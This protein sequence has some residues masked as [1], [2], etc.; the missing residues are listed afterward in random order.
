M[1][2]I[3]FTAFR[4]QTMNKSTA[5]GNNKNVVLD[6]NRSVR[7][8]HC[9][10]ECELAIGVG[11][12]CII[13]PNDTR[14]RIRTDEITL[15]RIT[16]LQVFVRDRAGRIRFVVDQLGTDDHAVW[17]QYTKGVRDLLRAPGLGQPRRRPN[18]RR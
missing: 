1:D 3:R 7:A 5:V 10:S 11:V 14:V 16:S 9:F 12:K 6:R 18:R 2:P 13:M 4:I 15:L 8:V 17:G